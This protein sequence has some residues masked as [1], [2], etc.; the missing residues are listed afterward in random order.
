MEDN[1]LV[2]QKTRLFGSEHH[3]FLF[4]NKKM[5][6]TLWQTI[7]IA[8]SGKKKNLLPKTMMVKQKQA[9]CLQILYQ[10]YFRVHYRVS[11]QVLFFKNYLKISKYWNNWCLKISKFQKISENVIK[12]SR[13]MKPVFSRHVTSP[14]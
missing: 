4:P 1:R 10:I 3:R 2:T 12:N 6:W 13:D 11:K 5:W 14:L 8:Q 7:L 9:S